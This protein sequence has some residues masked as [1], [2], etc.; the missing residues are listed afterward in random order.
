MKRAMQQVGLILAFI[1]FFL[2]NQAYS[3]TN[4]PALKDAPS[5]QE[6]ARIQGLIDK[7][8]TEGSLAIDG[9]MVEPKHAKY[10]SGG[11]REHYGL[12]KLEVKYTY[13]S[14]NGIVTKV[15]QLLAAKRPTPDIVWNVTWAWYKE[16][17]NRKQ[18]LAY[19]S[20]HYKAYTVSNEIGNSMPGYWVSDSYAFS[21]MWNPSALEK[22][23]VKNFNPTS[24]W[25]FTDPKFTKMVSMGNILRGGSATLWG[26]GLRKTL[27]D[28]WFIKIAK[29]KPAFFIKTA[30]GRDWCASGEYP[31]DL[32]SHAKNAETVKKSGVTVKLLYPQE[33]IVLLPFA[34]VILAPGPHP[35]AAK[36][37]IDYVRSVPGTNRMAASGV[38]LFFGRP[39]VKI[40]PNEF[41]PPVEKIKA[42]PMNWD[43]EATPEAIK[44]ISAWSQKIGASF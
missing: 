21:P 11:F 12:G 31:I 44:E 27:G 26:L 14:A 28:E 15:N 32:Y 3:E 35:N 10:I 29:L 33:G 30:Q 18:I 34:P 22:V 38:S 19:D 13:G 23:G 37:F 8:R 2:G 6:K 42:I 24:W 20:P 25:D 5:P 16:L 39:G 7:A 17:I 1:L 36:L 43:K 41:L 4:I 9:I 40:P